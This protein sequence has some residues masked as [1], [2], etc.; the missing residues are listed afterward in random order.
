MTGAA[1]AD[2]HPKQHTAVR[3]KIIDSGAAFA[4]RFLVFAFTIGA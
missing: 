4:M 3:Q 1:R 2:A